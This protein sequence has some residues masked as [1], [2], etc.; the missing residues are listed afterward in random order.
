[1][2]IRPWTLP[3]VPANTTTDLV[4][5]APGAAA[6]VVGLIICSD[7][8]VDSADV[9][10]TL[11][12]NTGAKKGGILKARVAP[13]ESIHLDTKIFIAAHATPDK[14]VVKSTLTNVSFIAS[15][16]EG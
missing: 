2:A 15:G 8:T 6:A 5:P 14:I 9:V 12:D 11:T 10:V 16:D 4:V 13:G 7:E 1:M 3:S